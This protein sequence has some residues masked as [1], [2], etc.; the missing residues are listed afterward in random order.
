[1]KTIMRH[2]NKILI[3]ILLIGIYSCEKADEQLN[4]YGIVSEINLPTHSPRG[5]AF[6]GN[7]LW[8]SDDSL[9][10]LYKISNDGSILKTIKM[11]G[12]KLTGFDFY[13]NN[14][15]CNNNKIVLYDTLISPHPFLCIYKLSLAGEKLDSILV[16]TSRL[17]LL[18]L[19]VCK[20]VIYGTMYYKHSY[21][22]Y[23]FH[24]D[25]E[26]KRIGIIQFHWLTGLTTKNDTIYGID[27]SSSNLK[28]RIVPLD[29]DFK[30]I[31]DRAV[32]IDSP[33]TDLV[34]VNNDLWI[35]DREARKL[36]KLK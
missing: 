9:N 29:S 17:E 3:V 7:Y 5:L 23:L 24:T 20:S 15:L 6:D 25:F 2:I 33:A 21:G 12:C 4:N 36:R 34:F 28:D 18:G 30:I 31:E 22:A 11:T 13:D 35:C 16:Q 8:Y 1:M 10:C 19:A 26:S 32:Y 14:I 27:K